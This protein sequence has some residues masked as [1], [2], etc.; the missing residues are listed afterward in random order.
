MQ[1]LLEDAQLVQQVH[2]RPQLMAMFVAAVSVW[3]DTIVMVR[4]LLPVQQGHGRVLQAD[5]PLPIVL[6]VAPVPT[7]LLL[8]LL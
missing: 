6:L 7:P 4:R 3:Q 2:G 1:V 8:A 5:Q